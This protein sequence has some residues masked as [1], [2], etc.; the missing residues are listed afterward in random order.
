MNSA[1][2]SPISV[3]PCTAM[4]AMTRIAAAAWVAQRSRCS[5]APQPTQAPDQPGMSAC[6]GSNA[7][8]SGQIGTPTAVRSAG[9][10]TAAA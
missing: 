1:I 4:D 3:R 10:R 7:P 8:H 6:A 9:R 2:A 5:R